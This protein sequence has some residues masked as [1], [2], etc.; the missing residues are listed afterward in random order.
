MMRAIVDISQEEVMEENSIAVY[1]ADC[2]HH[3]CNV[4]ISAILQH[5]GVHVSH[6]LEDNLDKIHSSLGVKL[7]IVHILRAI[8]KYFALTANYPKVKWI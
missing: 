2:L 3:L 8:E 6:V 5:V 4:W 7:D 1:K